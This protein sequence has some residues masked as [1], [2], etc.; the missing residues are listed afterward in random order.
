MYQDLVEL[1]L[2]SFME[3]EDSK[4]SQATK[5][6]HHPKSIMKKVVN[7]N[8][9]RQILEKERAN[10]KH[11]LQEIAQEKVRHHAAVLNL[12]KTKAAY[13][14]ED[15]QSR[16]LAMAQEKV[17]IYRRE[18][19]VQRA[20]EE[21]ATRRREYESRRGYENSRRESRGEDRY[22][23]V[24]ED[25]PQASPRRD[26]RESYHGREQ[27]STGVV[28]VPRE[29]R[30]RSTD[31]FRHHR[32]SVS[33]SISPEHPR[34]R[35]MHGSHLHRRRS[36][37]F[38][39]S[40]ERSRDVH[41]EGHRPDVERAIREGVTYT[42][43]P[44]HNNVSVTRVSSPLRTPSRP[45]P[46]SPLRPQSPYHTQ[47]NRSPATSTAVPN[48]L[49]YDP[50]IFPYLPR[51][52]L[53]KLMVAY[54]TDLTGLMHLTP[55]V[56]AEIL[57]ALHQSAPIAAERLTTARAAIARA[58][59]T[60]REPP[61]RAPSSRGKSPLRSRSLTP[62]S[63]YAP[64]PEMASRRGGAVR[65]TIIEHAYAPVR[66]PSVHEPR[67]HREPLRSPVY[68]TA[69]R[70]EREE[71]RYEPVR[72]PSPYRRVDVRYERN[73]ERD[74]I[75]EAKRRSMTETNSSGAS[76]DQTRRGSIHLQQAPPPVVAWP[77]AGAVYE[78]KNRTY[79]PGQGQSPPT[80]QWPPAGATYT[81]HAPRDGR[82]AIYTPSTNTAAPPAYS[83]PKQQAQAQP[84]T[85]PPGMRHWPANFDVSD[86]KEDEEIPLVAEQFHVM[87]IA[88]RERER[89]REQER[90][91]EQL[92]GMTMPVNMDIDLRVALLVGDLLGNMR[93]M[94]E[95]MG[96]L[97]GTERGMVRGCGHMH[98]LIHIGDHGIE[99]VKV[100]R[101]DH[102]YREHIGSGVFCKRWA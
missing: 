102:D 36:R 55:Q 8:A 33:V 38:S 31:R 93:T 86:F 18:E 4:M 63:W 89:A 84:Q 44:H 77:P 7:N 34:E 6:R 39:F 57:V 60:C 66:R 32:R 29:G 10:L 99:E 75:E 22:R 74:A 50:E 1:G 68:R 12:R 3:Y 81:Y 87:D 94:V 76:V 98:I 46:P 9:Q 65:E 83:P 80:A 13:S 11:Q 72:P 24:Y 30:G 101:L 54:D 82:P 28:K 23:E 5:T 49:Y 70:V 17:N 37:S 71:Q 53:D 96:A 79:I 19:D 59:N 100:A 78:Q 43:S 41:Y 40:P 27:Q 92:G 69:E 90:E 14:R 47:R 42:H 62:E 52:T 26:H 56:R 16:K 88:A 95:D 58:E 35:G 51:D 2:K 73:D 91:R 85:P 64:R 48:D 61:V 67:Q 97:D 15:H 20:M 25:Y 45:R 21:N